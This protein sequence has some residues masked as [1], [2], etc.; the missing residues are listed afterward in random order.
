MIF[1]KKIYTH[2]LTRRRR[3]KRNREKMIYLTLIY[4]IVIHFGNVVSWIRIHFFL[5][6]KPNFIG[7]RGGG[8]VV[9]GENCTFDVSVPAS[10]TF[11]KL[12]Q[13]TFF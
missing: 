3:Y 6:F 13:P 9:L 8:H 5:A 4:N 1:Q 12:G 7:G 2:E 11:R 10:H